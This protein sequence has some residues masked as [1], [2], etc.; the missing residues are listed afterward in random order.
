MDVDPEDVPGESSRGEMDEDESEDVEADENAPIFHVIDD[1]SQRAVLE[2]ISNLTALRLLN[3]VD[4]RPAPTPPT[5]TKR[6]KPPN[7]LVDCHGWQEIY[8]GKL[9]WIYDSKS[10]V[11]QCVRLVGQQGAMYG[12]AS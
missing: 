6:V 5:G 10:N 3:D 12:T 4:V 9:V 8:A 7:R 2:G 1:P 11:D